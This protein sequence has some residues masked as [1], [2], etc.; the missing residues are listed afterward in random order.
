MVSNTGLRSPGELEITRSTSEV[1]AC[2]SRASESSRVSAAERGGE[3]G[4][5]FLSGGRR[6]PRAGG[7][8]RRRARGGG[9]RGFPPFAVLGQGRATSPTRRPLPWGGGMG[10]PS[11]LIGEKPPQRRD[12]P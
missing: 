2:C 4:V 1:A 8:G 11:L 12:Q 6:P 5:F 10:R 3:R 7:A 9:R